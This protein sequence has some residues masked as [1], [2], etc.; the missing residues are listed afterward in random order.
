VAQN[1]KDQIKYQ[2]EVRLEQFLKNAQDRRSF[3]T[4]AGR[5]ASV[6]ALAPLLASVATETAAAAPT[7]GKYDFD[8][9]YN[10]LGTDSVHWDLPKRTEHMSKIIAGM[11]VADMDFRCAP[12]IMAGLRKRMEH[13]NWGYVD[14]DAPGPAA[15]MQGIIDWNKRRYG[16]NVINHSNLGIGT[17]VHSGLVAALRAFSPPGSKVLMITPIYNGF[18]YDLPFT[19][20][21]ANESQ[22][23]YVNGK[24][25]IDWDDLE[26]RMT[27]DT[28]TMILCNPNNPTGNAW[29]KAELNR[30]GELC[31][32]HKVIILSDEIHCDFVTKGQKYT[33]IST[34]DNKDIVNNSITFKS[35]S[36]SFSLA[37]MKCAWF[38][39]TNPELFKR[40][41]AMDRADLNTLGMIAEQ[42]AYAGG[43]DWLNSCVDY[44]DANH[45]YVGQYI[46][47]NIPMI[48]M[49][50]KAQ[51]TYLVWLDTTEIGQKIGAQKLADAE[52]KK[53]QPIS[54][55]TGKPT[56]VTVDDIVGHWFA[57]NAFVALNPGNTYGK[58]GL[59]HMRMNIA[60]ARPTLKAALDS[61]AGALKNLA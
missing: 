28:K 55:L 33:P 60:T 54:V 49:G 37:G 45:D 24:Y 57:K 41:A 12:S 44:I 36:K 16:I 48:K 38:F 6:L 26:R 8:T 59:N 50:Q 10:R 35:G 52:N 18:Y 31:L 30:I 9:P 39:S 21:V 43:E 40:T 5:G 15:F 53:P 22:M 47:A 56:V 58:G 4:G 3:L 61:M 23:K 32:K 11:G 13:E 17:G 20:T 25:E 14:M 29:T 46:K 1:A 34:L 27:P 2:R 42:S 7:G 19:N 51:S